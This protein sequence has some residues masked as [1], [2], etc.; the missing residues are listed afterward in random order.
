VDPP[1]PRVARPQPGLLGQLAGRRLV[2]G[3]AP[4]PAAPVPR[5]ADEAAGQR[6]PSEVRL[7]AA[8]DEQ[9]MQPSV[10][11]GQRHDV[12]G[13]R[14]R[15][16]GPRVVLHPSSSVILSF[17]FTLTE[18]NPGPQLVKSETGQMPPSTGVTAYSPR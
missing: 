13:D 2:E 11:D 17:R 8:L 14:G 16:V 10:A 7:L 9:H 4:D 3:L 18:H 6:R 12:D 15:L 5:G 1:Q